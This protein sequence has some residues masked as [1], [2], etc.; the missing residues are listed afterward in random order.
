MATENNNKTLNVPNLRFP[1]FS[2]EWEKCTLGD[3]T[4]NFSRRNKEEIHYPMFS[5]TN[6]KGFI[7]QSE[8]FEDREMVGEDIKAYKIIHK[9]DFAYNP[10]RINVGSIA[11]YSGE[12]PCMI[13]SLY[14]CFKT[15]PKIDNDWMMQLLKTPKMNF[16]YNINGEGGVR[17]YLFYPNFARIRTSYPTLQEQQKI[18]SFLTLLDERIVTQIKVIEDLKKLKSAITHSHFENSIIKYPARYIGDCIEQVSRRNKNGEIDNVLSVSNKSGFITQSE[19]FEDREIASEDTTNYKVVRLNDFA[20]NP[21][22]INVGSI[23]RLQSS[24]PGIVSPM[25]VCFRTSH[26]LLPEYFEHFFATQYFKHEMHKRLEGSVRLCLTFDSLCNI[27]IALPP[28]E[29]QKQFSQQ[30]LALENKV[31]N[32]MTLLSMY[33]SLKQYFLSQMFI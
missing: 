18:S 1:E 25:Y 21:A 16:Y 17:V 8:Q 10:A 7:P 5:V 13:S 19:Q 22:R 30:I 15:N 2:G 24:L 29:T 9:D 31:R 12:N 23:A 3:I 26:I 32:E 28:I 20:Y 33:Q 27:K 11:K 4:E 14:V 6:N